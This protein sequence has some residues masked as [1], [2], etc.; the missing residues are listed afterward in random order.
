M[1]DLS[2]SHPGL[3][4][5]STLGTLHSAYWTALSLKHVPCPLEN[6]LLHMLFLLPRTHSPPPQPNL[7]LPCQLLLLLRS[8]LGY[9]LSWEVFPVFWALGNGPIW[10]LNQG[11]W[12]NVISL[13]LGP[14][15]YGSG[16]YYWWVSTKGNSNLGGR[17]RI[18][19]TTTK[20][21]SFQE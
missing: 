17:V 8:W 11:T 4:Y 20:R 15:Q 12:V 19:S 9:H 7:P 10:V 14:A 2:W 1:Q 5:L 18:S 13:S 16:G 21:F 6:R 3:L